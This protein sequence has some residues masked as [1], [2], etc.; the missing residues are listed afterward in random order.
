MRSSLLSPRIPLLRYAV[1]APPSASASA[2]RYLASTTTRSALGAAAQSTRKQTGTI[3]DTFDFSG[4]APPLPQQFADLKREI[5]KNRQDEERLVETWR[6]VLKELE[7]VS[8]EVT[9]KGPDIVPQIGYDSFAK[10]LSDSQVEDIKRTGVVIV[11]GGVPAEEALGWKQ[12]IREYAKINKDKLKGSPADNIVFYELY[13]S[14]AQIAARSHPALIATQRTLLSLWNTHSATPSD[15]ALVSLTTPL[16]Y[17]DRLRIR[18]P[19]PS[20]FVLGCHLDGGSLERWEDEGYR[21]CYEKIFTEGEKGWRERDWLFDAGLRIKANPDLHNGPSQCSV[22]RPWQGWTSLSSTGPG[23]GTLRVIPFLN[24]TMAYILL[25]PFFKLRASS[26]RPDIPLGFEHWEL[27]L[28]GTQFPGSELTAQVLTEKT[29]PHL[30]LDKMVTSIPRVEPGDQV[31][32]HCDVVHAVEAQHNGKGDSSVLYIPAVPFT[33]PNAGYI[34]SQ[35]QNFVKGVSPPDFP[36]GDGEKHFIG[37]PTV[38]DIVKLGKDATRLFGVEPYVPEELG[39]TSGAK[40]AVE[41][42]NLIVF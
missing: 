37:R 2:R 12:S 6:G 31:Y 13:N 10:G 22:F 7:N 17:F 14:P 20:A 38:E 5:V 24:L 41:Q 30:R 34:R 27:N 36:G 1:A 29:H 18:P 33:V 26:E 28:D 25:R 11:K 3:E 23:E 8:G 4:T 40:E 19:G 15:P 42:G 32:W 16:S 39:L 9:A 35:L 21:R